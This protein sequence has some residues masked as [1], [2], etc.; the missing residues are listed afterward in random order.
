M[1]LILSKAISSEIRTSLKTF[2]AVANDSE[3]MSY[4]R[5]IQTA[6]DSKAHFCNM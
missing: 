4:F 3:L 1:T 6:L 5:T 2:E